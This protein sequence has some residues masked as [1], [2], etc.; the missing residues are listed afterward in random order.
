MKN[1]SR[2]YENKE[3]EYYPCHED[4]ECLNCLFCYCPLYSMEQCLGTPKYVMHNGKEVKDCSGCKYPHQAKNF[5]KIIELL[6]TVYSNNE[7]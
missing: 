2:F 7:E 4:I 1:T 6:K 5:D 3:C